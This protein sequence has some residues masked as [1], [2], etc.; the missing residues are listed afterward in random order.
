MIKKIISVI[1]ILI[2]LSNLSVAQKVIE[3]NNNTLYSESKIK[4]EYQKAIKNNDYIRASSLFEKILK[5]EPK[6]SNKFQY[7]E[8]LYKA[9]KIDEAYKQYEFIY[10]QTKNNNYKLKALLRMKNISFIKDN[11]K[12][13]NKNKPILLIKNDSENHYLCNP[14]S[15]TI[16]NGSVFRWDKSDFPIKVY[17]PEP[18]K[19]FNLDRAPSDYIKYVKKALSNW[20]ITSRDLVKFEITN[21]ESEANII[22]NWINYFENEDTWGKAN[23]PIFMKEFNKKVSFL[24]LAVRAQPGTAIY[25]EK[26]VLFSEKELIEIITHEIGHSL[27]LNHSFAYKGNEDIM[28]PYLYSKM[29]GYISKITN[30]DINT[31]YNLYSLPDNN[32]YKCIY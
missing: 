15:P 31:L 17:I 10:K 29:P 2:I 6:E 3:I 28:T 23:F 21:I 8:L 9:K 26:S 24:Y 27:G 12:I 13:L 32:I 5:I 30:R 7:A 4:K 1:Y 16:I 20:E 22:V 18:N 14:S 19:N 11:S 25:T